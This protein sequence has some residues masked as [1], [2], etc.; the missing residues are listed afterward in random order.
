[1]K[2]IARLAACLMALS[3]ASTGA[4]ASAALFS[5]LC[6]SCHNGVSHPRELAF[7]AAG[8]AA[9]LE[10][11]NALGMGA[12]GTVADRASVA[13][14][15][16]T[17]KP[18]ITLEA[19]GHNSPGTTI[20]LRDIKVSSA[21]NNAFLKIIARIE[22]VTPPAKGTVEY[23]YG[24]GFSAP[25]QVVYKPFPGRSGVDTWTYRGIATA[26][27]AGLDTT[28]RTASVVIAPAAGAPNYTALWWRS[29]AN[30]ENGW[31]LNVVHQGDVLFAT[32]FTYDTDGSALWLSADAHETAAGTF[33]G[34]LYQ[35]R[36]SPFDSAPY[37]SSRF[38][39]TPVGS[40]TLAFGDA[41]NGTFTYTLKGITQSKPITRFVYSSPVPTCTFGDASTHNYQDLW[42]RSPAGSENGWGVNI[43][44]QGDILFATWFTYGADGSDLWFVMADARKVAD[45]TYSGAIHRTASAP[46]NAYDASRFVPTQVGTG[47]LTF[48]DA[49]NG[50]F[51]YTIDG[52]AGSKP[53]TRYVFSSPGTACN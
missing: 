26:A 10:R 22:T 16:D 41:S 52:A 35:S 44:H 15:L 11:V 50:T 23:Q 28:V 20:E 7:N 40:V 1:M 2:S 18:A 45:R 24:L 39:A 42:W 13:A 46:F 47:T 4:Q 32:W 27:N 37:D 5:S 12:A 30:S 8:N 48:T 38:A 29:P 6:V 33:G 34:T 17:I 36:G 14:Y 43:A 51:S 3:G 19:V 49:S 53:I 21:V 25:S 9:I 31:G